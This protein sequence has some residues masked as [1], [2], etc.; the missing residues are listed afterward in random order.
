MKKIEN[1]TFNNRKVHDHVP[2]RRGPSSEQ[3][4]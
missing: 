1:R 3:S 2:S 4:E